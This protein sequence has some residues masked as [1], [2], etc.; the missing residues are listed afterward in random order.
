ML[1]YTPA[2]GGPFYPV[3]QAVVDNQS[4]TVASSTPE[5]VIV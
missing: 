1:N 3:A 5:P 4:P 2:L